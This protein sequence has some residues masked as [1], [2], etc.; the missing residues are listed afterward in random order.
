M[1]AATAKTLNQLLHTLPHGGHSRIL[2]VWE[3]GNGTLDGFH[4]WAE[5]K[6]A[7][8]AYLISMEPNPNLWLALVAWNKN[9]I[10][11]FYLAVLPESRS[12]PIAEIHRLVDDSLHWFYKPCKRD[13]KNKQR[14]EQF[15]GVYGTRNVP[16]PIPTGNASIDGFFD[17]LSILAHTVDKLGRGP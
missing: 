11:E 7:L 1:H 16:I 15:E 12:G 4:H 2:K 13:G 14:V 8:G 10:G 5:G 9:K 3:S 17:T 6:P